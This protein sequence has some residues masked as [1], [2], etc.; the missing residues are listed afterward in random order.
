MGG[1]RHRGLVHEPA[2]GLDE[3]D[4]GACG[5]DG[6]ADVHEVAM[7]VELLA[8][9]DR[10]VD[11]P[12]ELVLGLREH[13]GGREHRAREDEGGP[14]RE[15]REPLGEPP[16]PREVDVAPQL[17]LDEV[18]PGER[19]RPRRSRPH[20]RAGSPWPSP[21]RCRRGARRSRPGRRAQPARA[22]GEVAAAGGA[23]D[24]RERP[25]QPLRRGQQVAPVA[26]GGRE[27]GGLLGDASGGS[28]RRPR[29]AGRTRRCA[30]TTRTRRR[31]GAPRR[32]GGSRAGAERRLAERIGTAH[33]TTR[34]PGAEPAGPGRTPPRRR[35][36]GVCHHRPCPRRRRAVL[37]DA[38]CVRRGPTT[39][40]RWAPGCPSRACG[41]STSRRSSRDRCACSSPRT[42]APT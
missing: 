24:G 10:D 17:A 4:G 22:A 21:G 6:C 38:A 7:R 13:L 28:R 9:L 19:A 39:R 30:T 40:P 37:R 32:K 20:R 42:S 5:G 34:G 11:R 15:R 27:R 25:R 35:E 18:E 41:C 14:D 3:G 26:L 12:L 8:A 31:K 36:R 29:R 23:G 33:R 1:G 2:E 16:R